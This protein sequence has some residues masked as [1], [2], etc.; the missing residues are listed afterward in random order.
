MASSYSIVLGGFGSNRHREGSQRLAR[1]LRETGIEVHDLGARAGPDDLAKAA[2]TAGADAILV[3][4]VPIGGDA[5]WLGLRECCE[6][7]GLPDILLYTG[8]DPGVGRCHWTD[9][10]DQCQAAG[11]DR[12]FPP[13]VN[14]LR[15]IEQLKDDI[16]MRRPGAPGRGAAF[17]VAPVV[18]LYD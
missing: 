13:Q 9:I 3:S 2:V 18:A 14:L 11:Y 16:D 4:S 17:G 15:V 1:V 12:A 6:R 7:R 10:E 5:E 8:G